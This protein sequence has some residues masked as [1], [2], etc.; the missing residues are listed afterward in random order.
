M[1]AP[2]KLNE[3]RHI[4]DR[5]EVLFKERCEKL[6][7]EIPNLDMPENLKRS[8]LEDYYRWKNSTLPNLLELLRIKKQLIFE[9]SNLIDFLKRKQ[10]K[11]WIE[12]NQLFFISQE[13]A[14]IYNKHMWVIASLA[15]KESYLRKIVYPKQPRHF[16]KI[17]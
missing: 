4:L 5:Y 8:A 1:L 2:V 15:N 3:I 13:D 14:N 10:G 11:Y 7:K 12:D 17:F 9:I 6:G 16:K